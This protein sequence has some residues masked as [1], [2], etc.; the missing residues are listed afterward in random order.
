MKVLFDCLENWNKNV[1]LELR[2]RLERVKFIVRS[3]LS[4]IPEGI[5]VNPANL[6]ADIDELINLLL[7]DID[8]GLIKYTINNSFI[9][10]INF[11]QFIISIN[12]FAGKTL[13][14]DKMVKHVLKMIRIDKIKYCEET[15]IKKIEIAIEMIKYHFE[16]NENGLKDKIQLHNL[17][18]FLRNP[19]LENILE[20][21]L[22]DNFNQIYYSSF[23]NFDT[24]GLE[25]EEEE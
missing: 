1:N 16:N 3:N 20:N 7:S 12:E 18:N 24:I 23:L 8:T 5:P 22:V 25:I 14:E 6:P 19:L 11:D 2:E 9:K 4:V 15:K 10:R 17:I 13:F 21:N